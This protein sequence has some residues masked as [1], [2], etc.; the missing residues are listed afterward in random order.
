METSTSE[1]QRDESV[2]T[3]LWRN[4]QADKNNTSQ[5]EGKVPVYHQR[6]L[7]VS[8]NMWI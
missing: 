2:D 7:A 5:Q 8:T 1:S 3:Q 4:L 6:V